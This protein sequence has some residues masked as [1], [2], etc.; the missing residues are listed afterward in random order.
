MIN[1]TQKRDGW[2][3]CIYLDFEKA[4]DKVP[5][6]LLWKLEHIGGLEGSLKNWMKDYLKGR[7]MRTVV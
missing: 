3:D 5:H 1:I 7:E 4:F 6:K 2:V